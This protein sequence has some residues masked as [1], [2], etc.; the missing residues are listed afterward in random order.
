MIQLFI[1]G[2]GS[3]GHAIPLLSLVQAFNQKLSKEDKKIFCF[4][5]KAG[6]EKTLLEQ[7]VNVYFSIPAGKLRRYFS[8]ENFID[9]FK[10]FF[11][12]FLSFYFL[13]KYKKN[14]K[15][16]IFLSTGGFVAL[17][18]ATA[19]YL[20]G[21]PVFLHEQ[22]TRRGLANYLTT[23]FAK[24]IFLSFA[25][26][27]EYYPPQKSIV[28]G[29]PLRDAFFTKH[30]KKNFSQVKRKKILITGGGNGS[31]LINNWVKENLKQLSEKYFVVHQTG[32]KDFANFVKLKNKNYYPLAFLRQKEWV[33]FLKEADLI[34]TRA[35]AGI[36]NE[37]LFF[38]KKVIFIPLKIAQ[39]NEQ[40]YNALAAKKMINATI[41]LENQLTD[42]SLNLIKKKINLKN[43]ISSLKPKKDIR[44]EIINQ[45]TS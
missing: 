20:L 32:E 33:G 43:S 31:S 24:K 2:G 38:K 30:D 44:K 5:R 27:K 45:I 14:S 16:N 19:A 39:K 17:P 25:E 1:A 8:L 34:I 41:I 10:V 22:T 4:G 26:S 37:C 6:I 42:L 35:G 18:P 11:S 40:Y 9:I 3:G 13:L 36:V 12:F 15:K 21:I 28:T 29:Y 23:F 7:E